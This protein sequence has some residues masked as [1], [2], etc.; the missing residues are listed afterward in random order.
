MILKLFSRSLGKILISI[1]ILIF[2]TSFIVLALENNIDVLKSSLSSE[3]LL[4]EIMQTDSGM[5][6]D[7]IKELCNQTPEEEGCDV[8]QDP[9]K[10]FDESFN[11]ISDSIASNTNN[12][13]LIKILSIVLFLVGIILIYLGT[14]DIFT[15]IFKNLF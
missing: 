9:S 15:T 14:Q 2:L 10:L 1:S 11:V 7:E 3:E 12:I 6:F 8:I 13:N 4:E 5:S